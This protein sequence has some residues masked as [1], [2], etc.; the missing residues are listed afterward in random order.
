MSEKLCWLCNGKVWIFK[1]WLVLFYIYNH[2]ATLTL[3]INWTVFY[4][5]YVASIGTHA[6]MEATLLCAETS[7]AEVLSS[8]FGHLTN[9]NP[10][11]A[12]V[13]WVPGWDVYWHHSTKLLPVGP[14]LM[15]LKAYNLLFHHLLYPSTISHDSVFKYT[16]VSNQFFNVIY[17]IGLFFSQFVWT[18]ALITVLLFI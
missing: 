18:Y 6:V 15:N 5:N 10:W 13:H 1:L 9:S 16:V 11:S 2:D 8:A 3:Y 7:S 14:I 4:I 17:S 12:P